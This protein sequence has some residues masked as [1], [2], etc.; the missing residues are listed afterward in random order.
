[1]APTRQEV[2]RKILRAKPKPLVPPSGE[3]PPVLTQLVLSMMAKKP[4]DRPA[5]AAAVS[6]VLVDAGAVQMA[7][8]VPDGDLPS[9]LPG[10][11]VSEK[12]GE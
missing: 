5:S 11:G 1:V 4:S 10:E 2:F 12:V 9:D 7:V 3:L 8:Y 6:R